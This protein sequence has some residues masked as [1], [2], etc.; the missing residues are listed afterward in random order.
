MLTAGLVFGE[1]G[2]YPP[3]IG[4][5]LPNIVMGGLGLFLLIRAAKERPVNIGYLPALIKR[6][7]LRTVFFRTK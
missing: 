2:I 1:A 7:V 3:L 4:M 6:L 5:W